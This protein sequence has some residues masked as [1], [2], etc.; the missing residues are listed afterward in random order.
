[1]RSIWIKKRTFINGL[2]FQGPWTR[3]FQGHILV[4]QIPHFP[5]D[6]QMESVY[7][8]LRTYCF[9]SE[10]NWRWKGRHQLERRASDLVVRAR[11]RKVK[12]AIRTRRNH[13]KD[14]PPKQRKKQVP[15]KR[16]RRENP[17]KIQDLTQICKVPR[18]QRARRERDTFVTFHLAEKATRIEVKRPKLPS[19]KL[20]TNPAVCLAAI[21]T[22]RSR[23]VQVLLKKTVQSEMKAWL[24]Q[25]R[26]IW[27]QAM[28]H[29]QP[30]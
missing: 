19:K 12:K 29:S 2:N 18:K 20:F 21:V 28:I 25:A 17:Q 10:L 23:Q 3:L 7:I 27:C 11:R 26:K 4:V 8:V 9:H 14:L 1:M 15:N 16:E 24:S 5:R 30:S 22:Q 13:G 6:G